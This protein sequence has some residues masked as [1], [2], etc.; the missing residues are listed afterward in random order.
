MTHTPWAPDWAHGR[1]DATTPSGAAD[2]HAALGHELARAAATDGDEARELARR[3]AASLSPEARL[4]LLGALAEAGPV[5]GHG[6]ADVPARSSGTPGDGAGLTAAAPLSGLPTLPT[7]LEP[8]TA[9]PTGDPRPAGPEPSHPRPDHPRP[10]APRLD[11]PET[12]HPVPDHPRPGDPES[13]HAESSHSTSGPGPD[14]PKPSH[15]KPS[16]PKPGHPESGC[17]RPDD[18]GPGDPLFRPG[19]PAH[20]PP[21]GVIRLR[22]ADAGALGRAGAAFG[23]GAGPGLG[24]AWSDP[25]TLTLRI[26]A[27]AGIETLRAV[28]AVLDAAAVTAESLTVHTHELDDVLAV[29]TSLP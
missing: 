28:L 26:T 8:R 21:D 4:V 22:F 27:D 15:P 9:G 7:F 11:A 16:D 2:R 17:S 19:P 6:G 13:G 23:A 1:A 5:P 24:D 29:F 14:H 20:D 25:A 3:L 12:G 10:G 18:P